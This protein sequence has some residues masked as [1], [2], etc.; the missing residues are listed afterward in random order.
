MGSPK[1]A[2]ELGGRPL[3]NYPIA[4]ARL[5]GLA[6][7]VVAK[8]TSQLPTLDCARIIEPA[9]PTHPLAGIVAALEHAEEPIVVIACDLPLLPAELISELGHRRARLAM[10]TFPRPQPLVARYTPGLLPRLREALAAGSS[11]ISVTAELGGDT[12]RGPELRG[13]GDPERMFANV[14]DPGE[15]RRIERELAGGA[16]N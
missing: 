7:F 11:L 16:D 4:A 9:E 2:I 5:A 14:N 3:I 15:L 1:A 6:P 8:A 13:Y 10:P 12:L